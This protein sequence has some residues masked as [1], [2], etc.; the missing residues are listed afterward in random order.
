MEHKKLSLQEEFKR[1]SKLATFINEVG[2][3][4]VAA[5]PQNAQPTT[6]PAQPAATPQNSQTQL[7]DPK[8]PVDAN[9]TKVV[10]TNM[11]QGMAELI[12]ALPNTLKTFT[13]TKGD[14]DGQLETGEEQTQ[15]ATAAPQAGQQTAAPAPIK[16]NTELKF[17]ENKYKEQFSELDEAL[18]AGLIASAP[19][20]MK[21]G[22]TLLQKMGS[23]TNPNIIQK[24][25]KVVA[26]SGEKLHHTYI[27]VI[28]KL[29][30]PL[31]PSA[32]PETKH[33]A[34]EALFMVL[35]SGL[36]ASTMMVPDALTAVK[37]SE[38]ATY[39]VKQLPNIMS[40]I[41]FA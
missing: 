38:L 4:P 14:K 2:Q 16:E 21:Y 12:K 6:A 41:G 27:G 20:I 23:K 25:G 7:A 30:A 40:T 9:T 34:A 32:K 5:A 24:F 28:E 19:T 3:A 15:P 31:M 17:D 33:K 10:Q 8:Q 1:M 37:G 11:A 26:D 22:G 36:F 18:V 29:I 35:V 13:T 39:I